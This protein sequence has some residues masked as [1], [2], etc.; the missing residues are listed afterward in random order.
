MIFFY[1]A[2]LLGKRGAALDLVADEVSRGDVRDAHER[3]QAAALAA[4]AE[5]R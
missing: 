1:R 2:R 3:R 4:R 5:G